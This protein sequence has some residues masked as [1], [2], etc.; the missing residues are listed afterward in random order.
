MDVTTTES[1]FLFTDSNLNSSADV[2]VGNI[3]KTVDLNI[4][5]A[6]LFVGLLGML[7]N[8]IVVCV[9]ICSPRLRRKSTNVLIL[10]QSLIDLCAAFFVIAHVMIRTLPSSADRVSQD[11]FCRLWKS[12]ITIWGLFVSSTYNLIAMTLDRYVALVHPIVH[13]NRC[14]QKIIYVNMALVWIFGLGWQ[15]SYVIPTSGLSEGGKCLHFKM[16]PSLQIQVFVGILAVTLQFF[17]PLFII[18]FAYT[19]LALVL[20]RGLRTSGGNDARG[21]SRTREHRMLEASKNVFKILFTVSVSFVVCWS[22][23]QILYLMHNF[24]VRV[25][26]ESILYH[27]SVVLV[28]LNCCIN[29]I[30]YCLRYEEFQRELVHQVRCWN[31]S[32]SE[33]L[34]DCS[35]PRQRQPG[36]QPEA[37][38][39]RKRYT[40]SEP[41]SENSPVVN[42]VESETKQ[43]VCTIEVENPHVVD[44]V[45]TEKQA[46]ISDMRTRL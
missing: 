44:A 38:G 34:S 8:F 16:Y 9:M 45:D 12:N 29:P 13:R 5:L 33:V 25:D 37:G 22:P 26:F 42:S 35:T 3:T 43:V 28:F 31:R 18:T 39:E 27:L 20:R 32:S 11:I 24:G 23:N 6:Y 10:N 36:K 1:F 4:K 2:A 21:T 46:R 14:S 15:S 7:G 30:I 41:C 19:R 17:I 40:S